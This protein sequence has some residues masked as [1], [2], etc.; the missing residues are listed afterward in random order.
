MCPYCQIQMVEGAVYCL[1]C[2]LRPCQLARQQPYSTATWPERPVS[3]CPGGV[4]LSRLGRAWLVYRGGVA[5]RLVA[6]TTLA[7]RLVRHR[8]SLG[9]TQP[10]SARRIGM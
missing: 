5:R 1:Q 8:T 6:A 4:L 3:Q 9:M 10:E 2:R 7:G